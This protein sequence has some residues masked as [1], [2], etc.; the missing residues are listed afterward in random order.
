MP[1][2]KIKLYFKADNILDEE[3]TS[4]AYSGGYYPGAGQTFQLGMSVE[5]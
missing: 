1:T 4:S 2:E 5:L 3:Y